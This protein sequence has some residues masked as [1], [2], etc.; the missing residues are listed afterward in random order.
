METPYPDFPRQKVEKSILKFFWKIFEIF[1]WKKNFDKKIFYLPIGILKLCLYH[2]FC[3]IQQFFV[4][5]GKS[6]YDKYNLSYVRK[7]IGGVK[8]TPPR[9]G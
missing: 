4:I 9:V 3:I 5:F 1:F 2:R 8:F 7:T 6:F